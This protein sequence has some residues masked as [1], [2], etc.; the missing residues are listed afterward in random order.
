MQRTT[1]QPD[2]TVDSNGVASY[3]SNSIGSGS[4]TLYRDGKAVDG[5]WSRPDAA[6]PTSYLDA[7]GNPVPFRTGQT[8]VVLAPEQIRTS[9]G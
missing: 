5:T 9:E 3:K 6:S 7:A 2:G 4:F 8:W 1:A